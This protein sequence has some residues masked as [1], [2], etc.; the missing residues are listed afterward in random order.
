MGITAKE[1]NELAVCLVGHHVVNDVADC[2]VRPVE[3]YAGNDAARTVVHPSE[4][5]SD[6]EGVEA[7]GPIA[8]SC[9]KEECRDGYGHPMKIAFQERK[10]LTKNGSAEQHLLGYWAYQ[11]YVEVGPTACQHLLDEVT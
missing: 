2:V 8:V 11:S 5:K 1:V 9:T 3:D 6:E 10:Q 7:L 4:K